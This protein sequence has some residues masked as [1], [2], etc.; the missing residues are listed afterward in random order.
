VEWTSIRYGH[1]TLLFNGDRAPRSLDLMPARF[2]PLS[3]TERLWRDLDAFTQRTGARALALPHHTT[4]VNYPQDW[5]YLNPHYVRLAEVTSTHGDSLYEQRHPLNYAGGTGIPRTETHGQSITDALLMGHRL[6]LY[7][8]SD[9]HGGHPGHSLTHT[10]AAVG[11]QRPWS[12]WP[13]RRGKPYP[14]GLT[15]VHAEALSREALFDALYHS[16]VYASSD[17]GRPFLHFD[18]NGVTVGDGAALLLPTPETP[19]FLRIR[20]AQDGAPAASYQSSAATRVA[21]NWRPNWTATVEILKNGRLLHSF[22][23]DSAVAQLTYVDREPVAGA[24][25]T[26]TVERDGHFYLNGVSDNPVD[27]ASLNTGGADFYI[28]RVVGDNE[29]YAYIGAIWVSAE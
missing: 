19:R 13:T 7:A 4:K 6:T 1:Y 9:G 29:R 11:H 21:D 15:A 16:R 12:T 14:G 10:E 8:A 22:P 3:T 23:I 20:V 5:S 17:H 25:Y 24:A 28:I 2:G 18:V 27:P 26:Q